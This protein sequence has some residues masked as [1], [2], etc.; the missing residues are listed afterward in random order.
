MG[1]NVVSEHNPGSKYLLQNIFGKKMCVVL[2]YI[3][4]FLS[5]HSLRSI[6]SFSL[7]LLYFDVSPRPSLLLS[8]FYPFSLLSSSPLGPVAL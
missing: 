6:C 3:Y 5:S 1:K 4:N 2:M 8:M 7:S